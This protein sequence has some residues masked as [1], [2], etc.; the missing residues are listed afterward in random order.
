LSV[1]VDGEVLACELLLSSAIS[2]Y[3]LLGF[4]AGSYRP[5]KVRREER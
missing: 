5:L 4:G 2:G 3:Q 1:V